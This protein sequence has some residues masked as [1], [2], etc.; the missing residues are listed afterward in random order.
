MSQESKVAEGADYIAI[1]FE[2]APT[3]G[4]R[5]VELENNQGESISL[6]EW[7]KVAGADK[8]RWE[9]RLSIT[10]ENGRMILEPTS[11]DWISDEELRSIGAVP[12][13]ETA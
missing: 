4:A 7:V 12:T 5:F 1:V 8:S 2:G 6:G 3:H 13:Q 9:L 10:V 11:G